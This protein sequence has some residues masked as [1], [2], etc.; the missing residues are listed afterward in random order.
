M[1]HNSFLQ[2][3]VGP[4]LFSEHGELRF[5]R[6]KDLWWIDNS[7]EEH[8]I[9]ALFSFMKFC[10]SLK[11]LFISVSTTFSAGILMSNEYE[12]RNQLICQLTS[13]HFSIHGNHIVLCAVSN[14]RS[15]YLSP[16]NALTL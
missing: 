15:S 2:E 10:P 13:V 11:R 14:K 7:V 1:A 9:Q 5:S 16:A 6:L 8:N 12:T 4:W 3:I